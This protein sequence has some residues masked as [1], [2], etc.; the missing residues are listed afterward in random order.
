MLSLS[1]F[2][3]VFKS[4]EE[5]KTRWHT[6]RAQVQNAVRMQSKLSIELKSCIWKKILYF[7]I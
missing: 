4:I 2:Y 5:A 6:R 1:F 7:S 3:D